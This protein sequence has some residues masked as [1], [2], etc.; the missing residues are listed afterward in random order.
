MRKIQYLRWR[1]FPCGSNHSLPPRTCGGA[2][3]KL[4]KRSGK[5]NSSLA[6]NAEGSR[7]ERG[8]LSAPQERAEKG[9]VRGTR[10]GGTDKK[11][12][13]RIKLLHLKIERHQ[14]PRGYFKL[15]S[16]WIKLPTSLA[17]LGSRRTASLASRM[18]SLILPTCA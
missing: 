12:K 13:Q 17:K 14:N 11:R 10:K 1:S 15:S 18:A 3:N 4:P 9:G 7:R 8:N 2:G 5:G 16:C 6:E